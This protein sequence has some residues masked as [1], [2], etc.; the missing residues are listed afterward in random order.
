MATP[1]G[2]SQPARIKVPVLPHGLQLVL[3]IAHRLLRVRYPPV[4]GVCVLSVTQM[5]DAMSH[6]VTACA[7]GNEVFFGIIAKPAT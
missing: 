7:K 5:A 6:S 1:G 3:N 2:A 4:A